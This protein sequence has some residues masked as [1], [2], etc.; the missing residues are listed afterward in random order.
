MSSAA[1][2]PLGIHHVV[3]KGR[4]ERHTLE[5]SDMKTV[6]PSGPS[7]GALPAKSL[8]PSGESSGD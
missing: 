3:V 2:T 8:G 7:G 6:K 1:V 4:V 5:V